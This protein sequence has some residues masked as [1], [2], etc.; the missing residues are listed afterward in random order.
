VL[1]GFAW[2]LSPSCIPPAVRDSVALRV[3]DTLGCALAAADA[4]WGESVLAPARAWGAGG[5]S[6]VAAS[7][8]RVAAPLAALANGALAHGLDFDDTHAPSITHASA[9]ILPAVLALGEEQKLDGRQ[10]IAAAVAGYET[11]T[12]LGMAVPGRFH[13]RGWHA[14]RYAAPWAPRSPPAAASA[15]PRDRS[16]RRW[17]SPRAS[18]RGCSS[19]S[20]TALP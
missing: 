10:A 20:R 6:S 13:A 14:R 7:S 12:R 19:S 2:G 4:D 9:V 11:I 17:A 3:L 18:P 15:S 8:L 5:A 1:A 16:R